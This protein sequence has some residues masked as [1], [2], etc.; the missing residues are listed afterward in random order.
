MATVT[1]TA[2]VLAEAL[3]VDRQRA[4]RL[5]PVGVALVEN[6]TTDA[7]EAVMNEACIRACGWL[8]EQ[9]AAAI[10]S[11]TT[12]DLTTAYAATHVSALRHSGAM[13]LLSGFLIR[14]AGAIG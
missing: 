3:G 9:P 5:L 12:G 13:A 4:D 14:R 10:R 8:A 1:L 6:Y 2:D 7:P 11:E